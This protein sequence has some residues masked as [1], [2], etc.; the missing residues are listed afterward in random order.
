MRR[1]HLL[2]REWT[3][4]NA[5]GNC[6]CASAICEHSAQRL[7]IRC[8]SLPN[9]LRLRGNRPQQAA[10]LANVEADEIDA[11]QLALATTP[12]GMPLLS[13]SGRGPGNSFA[14]WAS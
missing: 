13:S 5:C 10:G 4:T 3:C 8:D 7:R 9:L 2:Q 12:I 6:S 1:L 11:G 14:T